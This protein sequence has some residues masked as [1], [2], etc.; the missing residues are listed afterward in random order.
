MFDTMR[1][2]IA[3]LMLAAATGAEAQYPYGYPQYRPGYPPYG[4]PYAP[5]APALSPSSLAQA[6]LNA[7]NAVRARVG[8]PPLVWSAQVA[9]VAQDWANNLIATGAFSHRPGNRYG[10]NLYAIAGGAASPEQVVGLWADEARGY[11]LRSNTCAGECGHYTQIVWGK[12][13]ALG[14]AVARDRRREVWVCD[15]DP[16]GNVVGYRPY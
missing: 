4:E 7:H 2:L 3:L 13:Q 8:V 15:Y 1:S 11:D 10:E 6:M 12:T 16:P 14:C 9:G 5:P